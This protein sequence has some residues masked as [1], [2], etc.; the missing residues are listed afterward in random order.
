M[1]LLDVQENTLINYGAVSS[2]TALEMVKGVQKLT[3]SDCA[4]SITGIA[5]PT[6][7]SDEK[8]VG[9]VFIGCTTVNNTRVK[10]FIFHKERMLNKFRFAYA[11]LNLLRQ[12]LSD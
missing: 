5:G 11:A 2:E 6:G 4:L 10:K 8:P 9:L 7:G 12:D 1:N 3:K